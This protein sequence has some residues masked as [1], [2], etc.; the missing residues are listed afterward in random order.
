M[1]FPILVR[2]HLY[3]E[4]GPWLFG[5]MKK[6]LGDLE[7]R[8]P[9]TIFYTAQL[10]CLYG[11][12]SWIEEKLAQFTLW[13]MPVELWPWIIINFYF[14]INH[15]PSKFEIDLISCLVSNKPLGNFG[16]SGLVMQ[17]KVTITFDI[18]F[19][20]CDLAIWPWSEIW[21]YEYSHLRNIDMIWLIFC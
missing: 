3:N 11:V 14:N 20:P 21:W 19:T 9:M 6:K 18:C 5:N 16:D 15:R 17:K 13:P 4:S 7:Y 10:C 1:G 8:S 2:W 12:V